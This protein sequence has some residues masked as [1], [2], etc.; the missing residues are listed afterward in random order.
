VR[1]THFEK[2]IRIGAVGYALIGVRLR[3]AENVF[4]GHGFLPGT[5]LSVR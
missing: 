1:E 5:N 2:L 3:A 4:G